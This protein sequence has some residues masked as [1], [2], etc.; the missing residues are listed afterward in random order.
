MSQNGS[1]CSSELH[2]AHALGELHFIF[3]LRSS[4]DASCVFEA[5][6][7]GFDEAWRL[8]T[9]SDWMTFAAGHSEDNSNCLAI[10]QQRKN[11]A[12]PS[13]NH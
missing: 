8:A 13:A 4:R 9:R 2:V 3:L 10:P 7:A 1:A 5:A 6:V 12:E 11:A